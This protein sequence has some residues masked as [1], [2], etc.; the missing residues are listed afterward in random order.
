MVMNKGE[1]TRAAIVAEAIRLAGVQGLEGIS[2]GALAARMKLSK[3]GL[4]GHFG[5]KA[6]LQQAVLEAVTER[7]VDEVIRPALREPSGELRLRIFFNRWLAWV[8]NDAI[9]GGCPLMAAAIELEERPGV[10]RDYLAE[11]QYQFID[12]LTRMAASAVA[13]GS[14][15]SDSDTRQFAFELY[16]IGLSYNVWTR[17][18][19]DPTAKDRALRA[20]GNL[21]ERFRTDS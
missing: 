15:H 5:S 10:L 14:F 20:F 1:Q 9:P 8:E 12:A 17:L 4:F 6:A 19:R 18:L 7:F 16:G 13:S 2:I 11:Q 21:L 3:S